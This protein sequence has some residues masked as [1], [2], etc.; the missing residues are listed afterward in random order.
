MIWPLHKSDMRFHQCE[1]IFA[2]GMNLGEVEVARVKK[3]PTSL[4]LV[5]WVLVLI[6]YEMCEKA[7]WCKVGFTHIRKYWMQMDI[8]ILETAWNWT[9]CY[10]RL[11][12]LFVSEKTL[13]LNMLCMKSNLLWSNYWITILDDDASW[14]DITPDTDEDTDMFTT[15]FL[16][17]KKNYYQTKLDYEKVTK[18][19]RF[20][21]TIL[22][23]KCVYI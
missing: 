16:L 5:N 9:Y 19:V 14:M 18:W 1:V 12:L 22:L 8:G 23:C 4:A 17:H 10:R 7:Q 21:Y 3:S 15:E 11:I 2:F 20:I 13:I 6:L